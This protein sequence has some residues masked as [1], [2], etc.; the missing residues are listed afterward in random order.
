LNLSTTLPRSIIDQA[1]KSKGLQY[2]DID[3]EGDSEASSP[4]SSGSSKAWAKLGSALNRLQELLNKQDGKTT[5][6]VIVNDLGSADWDEPSS[7]VRPINAGGIGIL[8]S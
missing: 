5:T 8:C 6:R 1:E 2:I 3:N 4:S 7:H